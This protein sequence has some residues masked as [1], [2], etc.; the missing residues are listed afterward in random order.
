MPMR[1]IPVN[2]RPPKRLRD[3]SIYILVGIICIGSLVTA[4]IEGVSEQKFMSWFGF[5]F[6]TLLLFGQFILK[7]K[8]VWERRSF[9]LVTVFFLLVHV[10]TFTK[11][12]HA[13]RQI[14]G[15]EWLLLVVVEMAVLIMFRRSVYKT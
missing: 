1:E 4:A 5:A 12:L 6:F 10:T 2:S 9:W 14:S 3:F 13:G 15:G 7:S 8:R 11:L